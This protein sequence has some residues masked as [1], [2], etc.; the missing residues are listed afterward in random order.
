MRFEVMWMLLTP[1]RSLA[2]Y[3][4]QGYLWRPQAK[5]RL[6]TQSTASAEDTC[7]ISY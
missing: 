7:A 5:Q 1:M 4:G 2:A 6:Q 3:P